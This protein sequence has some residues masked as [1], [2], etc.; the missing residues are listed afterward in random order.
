[1]TPH[2][3]PMSPQCSTK[4]SAAPGSLTVFSVISV[5]TEISGIFEGKSRDAGTGQNRALGAARVAE[6]G[7]IRLRL[8]GPPQA[9]RGLEPA[10]AVG[11]PTTS[12]RLRQAQRIL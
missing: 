2:C 9:G 7:Y 10:G 5:I 1:L 4:R 8:R 12:P 3:P 11:A 6:V